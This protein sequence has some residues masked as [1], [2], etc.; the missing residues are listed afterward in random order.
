MNTGQHSGIFGD[1]G[2]GKTTLMQLASGPSIPPGAQV[3]VLGQRLGRRRAAL[4]ERLGTVGQRRPDI[5][6]WLPAEK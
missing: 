4:R 3:D 1:D 6:P 2:G 5:V